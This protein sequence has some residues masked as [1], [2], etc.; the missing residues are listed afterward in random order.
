LGVKPA[1]ENAWA[2]LCF[3]GLLPS[4]TLELLI[5]TRCNFHNEGR[6]KLS[7]NRS[8]VEGDRRRGALAFKQPFIHLE[9]AN[10]RTHLSLWRGEDFGKDNNCQRIEASPHQQH[11]FF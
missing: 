11:S 3:G 1:L 2:I 9:G 5:V 8:R 6:C 10:Y 4:D 7:C